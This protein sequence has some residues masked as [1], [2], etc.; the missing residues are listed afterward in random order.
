[1]VHPT[2]KEPNMTTITPDPKPSQRKNAKANAAPTTAPAP[3]KGPRK[4]RGQK[5]P[6]WTTGP[7]ADKLTSL[8]SM[9]MTSANIARVA[10]EIGVTR[11]IAVAAIQAAN[12]KPQNTEIE[13]TPAGVATLA[14]AGIDVTAQEADDVDDGNGPT[15]IQAAL[16]ERAKA[17]AERRAKNA[18]DK[19]NVKGLNAEESAAR[20][21]KIA[22]LHASFVD[23]FKGGKTIGQIAA[24]FVNPDTG[25]P[26][27]PG[28]VR[29]VLI[30]AGLIKVGEPRAPKFS[31]DA[32][33]D[34]E[35]ATITNALGA[36]GEIAQTHNVSIA[37]LIKAF[38]KA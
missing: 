17:S 6:D 26:R 4:P 10:K 29:N 34:D 31:A 9:E 7:K 37:S 14:A 30:A 22:A 11:A 21:A 38:P 2:R 20:K 18:A 25:K 13:I 12:E 27:S 33:T 36:I 28:A 3:P 8:P 5:A 32:L 35:M 16:I 23:A 15:P 1:M 19:A 24:E